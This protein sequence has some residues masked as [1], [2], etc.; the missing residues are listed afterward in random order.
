MTI[1]LVWARPAPAGY[2]IS[3]SIQYQLATFSHDFGNL[4][5]S[6]I[7][8]YQSSWNG[9][10]SSSNAVNSLVKVCF[11]RWGEKKEWAEQEWRTAVCCAQLSRTL[12]KT[13]N[14]YNYNATHFHHYDSQCCSVAF[15]KTVKSR[16]GWKP[17]IFSS[18]AKYTASQGALQFVSYLPWQ[19]PFQKQSWQTPT[20]ETNDSHTIANPQKKK[21]NMVLFFPQ[22]ALKRQRKARERSEKSYWSLWWGRRTRRHYAKLARTNTSTCSVWTRCPQSWADPSEPCTRAFWK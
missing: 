1:V 10:R 4:P 11:G 9:R 22:P 7:R 21:K 16:R 8:R 5:F 18:R 2:F 20:S 19:H 14:I 15:L 6:Y 12:K 13:L 3:A 17:F